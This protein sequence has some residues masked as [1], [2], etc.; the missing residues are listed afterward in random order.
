MIYLVDWKSGYIGGQ[1]TVKLGAGETPTE[2]KF[3]ELIA[4]AESLESID[5]VKF[6]RKKAT[7]SFGIGQ[8]QSKRDR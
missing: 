6:K 3:S 4:T 1:I 8:A 2:H 5:I 7:K